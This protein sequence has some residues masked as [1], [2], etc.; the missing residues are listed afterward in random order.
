M[1]ELTINTKQTNSAASN[2]IENKIIK[3]QINTFKA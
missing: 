3:N 1:I 2:D